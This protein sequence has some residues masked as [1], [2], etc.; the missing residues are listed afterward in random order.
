MRSVFLLLMAVTLAGCATSGSRIS[1]SQMDRI[2]TGQTTR[3]EMISVFGPPNTE[4]VN[5]DGSSVLGWGYAHIGFAGIGTEVQGIAVVIGPDGRVVS[6]SRNGN[7]PPASGAKQTLSPM[8]APSP[9]P[10]K[11]RPS[12]P[13]CTSE[14]QCDAMWAEAM[15]QI[16]SLSR[17]RIQT[18]T[19]VFAQTYNPTGAGR[20]GASVRKMPSPDGSTSIQAE[21]F[22]RYSCPDLTSSATDLFNLSVAQAGYGFAQPGGVTSGSVPSASMAPEATKPKE[23]QLYELQQRNL[24]YEQ[25][26]Q[27]YRRIMGQ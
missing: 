2:V 22:C 8:A 19:D 6:Y 15:V 4:T 24:P 26:Q 7:T 10:V 18:A 1:Q 9:A 20:M 12:T 11:S 14:R 25:Y 5:A 27:E 17:M 23:Q 16:Q 13:T 21:F 3:D